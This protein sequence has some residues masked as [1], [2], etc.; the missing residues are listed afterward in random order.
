MSAERS[1]EISG[2]YRRSVAERRRTVQE[3][4]GLTDEQMRSYEFPPGVPAATLE[5]MIENVIGAFPLP[6][7]IATHFR[8]NG[9]DYL[10]P[11]ALEEPSVVAA[12][13]N[14][15]KL[16][17]ERG[18]FTAH[19]TPPVMIGQIQVVQVADPAGAR[20][21]ILE[22]K[23]TLLAAA[24]AKDPVLVKFGGGAKDLEVRLVPSSR[25]PMVVVHLLVDARDAGGMNAVNTMCEALAPEVARLAQ[26]RVVLRIISNLAVHRLARAGRSSR[27][28]GWRPR[29]PPGRRWSTRS[30]MPT[31]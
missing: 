20:L 13:S 28:S 6:L 19:A 14:T 29:R 1:S 23:E 17:R 21:R 12:A 3:W 24:N 27:P 22:A 18:G 16:A 26:G 4:A 7:G 5:R 30:S 10:I 11:M 15:A 31:P 9:K 8:I 25:G 2:F